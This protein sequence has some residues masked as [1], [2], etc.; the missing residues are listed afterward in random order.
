MC[1]TQQLVYYIFYQ[2]HLLSQNIPRKQMEIQHF[3]LIGCVP[4]F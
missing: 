3:Q 2:K 4:K 1:E